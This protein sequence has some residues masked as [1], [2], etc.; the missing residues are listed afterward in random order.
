M[1][2]RGTTPNL[3][4]FDHCFIASP[5]PPSFLVS[6][7]TKFDHD[8]SYTS[9]HSDESVSSPTQPHKFDNRND[10]VLNQNH[11][12]RRRPS[13]ND[14]VS[15]P[16]QTMNDNCSFE[17]STDKD[18]SDVRD[19][20][21]NSMRH[22]L[23][24]LFPFAYGLISQHSQNKNRKLSA[25]QFGTRLFHSQDNGSSNLNIE[26]HI[27]SNDFTPRYKKCDPSERNS[28]GDIRE[29]QAASG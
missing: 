2:Q 5:Y 24:D 21:C 29:Q 6:T 17:T 15:S 3:S 20:F 26:D 19:D 27:V 22:H 23:L 13:S 16:G 28:E 7:Q 11:Q 4:C 10:L 1:P 9:E 8:N 25:E 18:S 14:S 12:V